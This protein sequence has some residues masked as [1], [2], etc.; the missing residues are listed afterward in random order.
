[1]LIAVYGS[2]RRGLGNHRNHLLNS[3]YLGTY[4]TEPIYTLKSLGSF[5][6]LI[7]K[8]LT[9]VTMEVFRVNQTE[10]DGIDSLEGY[11]GPKSKNNL[12]DKE[13][14]TTPYGE[15]S[16]YFYGEPD[17]LTKAETVEGGDWV[18]YLETRKA[19]V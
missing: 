11:S 3:T 18:D 1:M 4:Q 14:I 12:Y 17:R 8:G 16:V 15:A 19:K 7:K 9:S 13:T 6:G 2:L 5:P 10:A